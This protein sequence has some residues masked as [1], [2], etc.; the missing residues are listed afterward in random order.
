VVTRIAAHAAQPDRPGNGFVLTSL[1]VPRPARQGGGPYPTVNDLLVAALILTVDQWNAAHG[2][3]SGTIRITVPVNGRDPHRRWEGPGN[4][5]RLIR[6]TAGPGSRADAAGL[7]A[8]VAAQTRAGKRQPSP[9]LDT[10][11]RLLAAGWAPTAVKRHAARLTRRLARPVCTDTS[12]VS[13]LGV[14]PD[15]PSFSGSGQEPLWFSGPSPMPRGLGVGAVTI[16][17]R[18][19]LCV[20]YRPALLDSEAAAD[21]TAAYGLVLAGLAAPPQGRPP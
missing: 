18:L 17:G 19:H 4:L 3:R 13:N 7:L 16:A 12:L 2:R 1:P 11:S 15:P 21:F 6:V 5:S 9:G 20:H 10:L 8:H 14:L